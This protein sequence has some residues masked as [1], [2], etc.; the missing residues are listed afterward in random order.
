MR[1]QKYQQ[2]KRELLSKEPADNIT[3]A[4]LMRLIARCP[5]TKGYRM[6]TSI[7]NLTSHQQQRQKSIQLAYQIED[8]IEKRKTKVVNTDLARLKRI[9]QSS[10]DKIEEQKEFKDLF[11]MYKNNFVNLIYHAETEKDIQLLLKFIKVNKDQI[12]SENRSIYSIQI[13]KLL[14]ILDLPDK[15]LELFND[16]EMGEVFKNKGCTKFLMAQLNNQNRF[17]SVVDV[18]NSYFNYFTNLPEQ[19]SLSS[20]KFTAL[21]QFIVNDHIDLLTRAL[22]HLNSTESMSKFKHVYTILTENYGFSLSTSSVINAVLF[23]VNQSDV[24]VAQKIFN[25]YELI[26]AKEKRKQTLVT[27]N[28]KAIIHAKANEIPSAISEIQNICDNKGDYIKELPDRLFKTTLIALKNAVE[29]GQDNDH[30]Q[31]YTKLIKTIRKQ[32]NK[33]VRTNDLNNYADHL[34]EKRYQKSIKAQKQKVL[35]KLLKEKEEMDRELRRKELANSTQYNQSP[36]R[37]GSQFIDSINRP[38]AKLHGQQE[39][40]DNLVKSDENNNSEEEIDLVVFKPEIHN[41]MR[42][43]FAQNNFKQVAEIFQKY[44]KSKKYFDDFSMKHLHMVTSSLLLLN[45]KESFETMKV[46]VDACI[47]KKIVLSSQSKIHLFLLACFQDEPHYGLGYLVLSGIENLSTNLYANLKIIACIRLHRFDEVVKEIQNIQKMDV[48][49]F[50]NSGLIIPF[51]IDYFKL[52]A[53]KLGNKKMSAKADSFKKTL[54]DS[55]QFSP[56]N[57]ADYCDIKEETKVANEFFA[58]ILNKSVPG[59]AESESE[60]ESIHEKIRNSYE[61]QNYQEVFYYYSQLIHSYTNRLRNKMPENYAN[62][63]ADSILKNTTMPLSEIKQLLF[64][65]KNRYKSSFSYESQIAIY[66]KLIETD[67]L[68][69]LEFLA[70]TIEHGDLFLKYP[71]IYKNILSIGL[72]LTDKNEYALGQVELIVDTE[73]KEGTYEGKVFEVTINLMNDILMNSSDEEMNKRIRSLLDRI[74][75]E[76]R[77]DITE[78]KALNLNS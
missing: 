42:K 35:N 27:T 72:F 38:D 16:P 40:Q 64:L 77:L 39:S 50:S 14:Y 4:S 23:S 58:N 24:E 9:L 57:L 10:F 48:Q 61:A 69:G 67:A 25:N 18:F 2:Q 37:H 21:Q 43:M 63:I 17:Q 5:R 29:T 70:D 49:K 34:I 12:I 6:N 13:F 11:E 74:N 66:L 41:L 3:M 54:T 56:M 7:E 60:K 65:I 30:K 78:L 53:S 73:L 47:N 32:G 33:L 8:F 15:S 45:S 68:Y 62:I 44:H 20:K 51:V 71:S 55:N 26:N 36:I 59:K 52:E 1:D 75:S 22:W 19:D 31:N 28:L 46:L 76:H